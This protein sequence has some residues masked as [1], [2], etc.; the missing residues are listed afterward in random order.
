VDAAPGLEKL[1]QSQKLKRRAFI[2]LFFTAATWPFVGYGQTESKVARIGVLRVARASP[3]TAPAYR[4]FF[5][6]LSR[7]GFRVGDNLI[8]EMRW[9]DEDARGP[10]EAAGELLRLPVDALVVEGPEAYLKAAIAAAVN[11]PIVMSMGNFDPLAL[12]YIKS[13]A[14]PGGNVTGIFFQRPE[15]AKKQ[16][17]LLSQAFPGRT[18]LGI[19]WDAG[20]T[21]QFEAAEAAARSLALEVYAHK[22]ERPPYDI[23]AAFRALVA[24]SIQMLLVESSPLFA[25][26]GRNI[27]ELAMEH[28]LPTMFIV[29]SYVDRGGLMSYGPDRIAAL[30][31]TATYV[32][33]ILKGTDPADLPVE[34]PTKYE[35]IVNLKTAEELGLAIP[36]TILGRAD[37]VIE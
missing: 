34:Q 27:A 32:D 8:A 14:R 36:Q 3:S 12:G 10:E 6:E 16:V 22:F 23:D 5:D 33:K 35:L 31:L 20:S 11:T 7:K 28:R 30:R 9:V 15:L 37:E 19:L 21:D 17:D 1:M 4:A 25:P 24:S 29:R 13:L 2:T 26:Y 18:R